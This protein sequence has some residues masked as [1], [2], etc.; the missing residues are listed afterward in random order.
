[1]E[2]KA[3]ICMN[4]LKIEHTQI[5][6]RGHTVQD[7]MSNIKHQYNIP[8][9]PRV[10]V[11]DVLAR[12]ELWHLI[13]VSKGDI[14][15]VRAVP[16]GGG[17]KNPLRT[18]LTIAVMAVAMY[19]SGG[20]LGGAFGAGTMGAALLGVGVG[21]VGSM[22][23]DAIAPLPSAAVS[24]TA[25][26]PDS[27]SFG[28]E[29]ARNQ[30]KQYGS[31]PVVLG[32]HRYAP[33]YAATPYTEILGDDQYIRML[34]CFGYGEVGVEELKI[35]ET[36]LTE[37]ADV[38]WNDYPNFDPDVD[39]LQLFPSDV[40]EEA[41]SILL[42]QASGWSL[43]TS[44]PDIDEISLDVTATRG[45]VEY[46]NAGTRIE[47]LVEYEMQYALTGTSDWSIGDN[48]TEFIARTIQNSNMVPPTGRHDRVGI[49][50]ETGEIV[51]LEGSDPVFG[52]GYPKP[53]PSDIAPLCGFT[54]HKLGLSLVVINF[55][56]LR[57]D[58]LQS[59]LPTDF[60]PT[61][62]TII[63]SPPSV[64]I[65]ISAG[66]LTAARFISG[67]T[68]QVVRETDRFRVPRG[69][70]D[71]RVRRVT[72]DSADDQVVDEITWTA[73]RS[74][75]TTTPPVTRA[76]LHLFE[77]RIRA[78]DQLNGVIDTFNALLS[79]I[80]PSWDSDTSTWITRPTNNPADIVRFIWQGAPNKRALLDAG[81]DLTKLQEWAEYCED[82][83][84]TF[85][86]PIDS[87]TSVR[88]LINRVASTGRASAGYQDGKHTVIIDKLQITPVQM[89][90][91]RN[92]KDFS[93]EKRFY[94]NPHGFRVRF[95]N[96]GA[97]FFSDERVVY[98][99]GYNE[100]NATIFE[101]LQMPGITNSDLVYK[102]AKFHL[103]QLVLRPETYKFKTDMENVVCTRGDLIYI[104]NDVILVGLTATRVKTVIDN[105]T[106]VTDIILEDETT[107][108]LGTDYGVVYR[109]DDLNVGTSQVAT[110]PGTGTSLELTA[111]ILIA[112]APS[113]GD[114]IT[115]GEFGQ[116]IIEAMVT[117]VEPDNDF[118]A[119]IFSV[120]YSAALYTAEGGTIPPFDTAISTPAGSP[121]PSF[122][123]VRSDETVQ[124]FGPNGEFIPRIII[125][126]IG[127]SQ[128]NFY[129]VDQIEVQYQALNA[130]QWISFSP[131]AHDARQLILTPV[132]ESEIYDIRFRYRFINNSVG[133]W[134]TLTH[135]V[136]GSTTNP[137]DVDG[138][139]MNPVDQVMYF[140]WDANIDRDLS[141]YEIRYT[142]NITTPAWGSATILAE[143][144]S[145][146]NTT[147]NAPLRS[148]TYM[149]KAAD[150]GGRKSTTEAVIITTGLESFGFNQVTAV[151][152]NPTYGGT[153][154]DTRVISSKLELDRPLGVMVT[155]GTYTFANAVDL[156]QIYVSRLTPSIT[157]IGSDYDDL[158]SSWPLMSDIEL[159]S[160]ATAGNW[161]IELQER[162]TDDDPAGTP[163][164]SDWATLVV[165]DYKARAFEFRIILTSI[166]P[167]ITPSI[168][169]LSITIDMPDRVDA[170]SLTTAPGGTAV[171]FSPAFKSATPEVVITIVNG[172]TGDYPV[173]TAVSRTG[174]TIQI[175][176]STGTGVARDVTW[177]AKGYG[178]VT[179]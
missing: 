141:H 108:A 7:I 179:T 120:P 87:Q 132:I 153:H 33:P 17:G 62:G 136:V 115:F 83:G 74:F 38:E 118:Q 175:K 23:I 28:I 177:H 125:D 105:G 69:Q 127:S 128:I 13:D 46:D 52:F 109:R 44:E 145:K 104:S 135:T 36:V 73:L 122:E 5:A 91:A 94:T 40:K 85:N 25:A 154:D 96:E 162:H 66:T 98:T 21:I 58:T 68:T 134:A 99:A 57:D 129:D 24:S 41:L 97:G 93:M 176:D 27:Q 26:D 12:Q 172:V 65:N 110:V 171:L 147:F 4:P 50:R 126:L 160:G 92:S 42:E 159:M 55:V 130:G 142:D 49:H 114:L 100:T 157:V 121:A 167:E 56:D 124:E 60:T 29:G 9:N 174:F 19:V 82:N 81:I 166:V 8:V 103:A 90:S 1:M 70:Y 10:F 148:G 107:M 112:E 140:R 71:I 137:A 35:G 16:T 95:P 138:F 89:F 156:S 34:F 11:N 51:W 67:K 20:A 88:E 116:E 143:R 169:A 131:L 117:R 164:W 123:S 133:P 102:H 77:M 155:E 2:N 45:M 86:Q 170:G 78:T 119:S 31:I 106:H 79:S 158:M 80:I 47:R 30:V 146:F 37:Y 53:F 14:I 15:S 151:T 72:V 32:Y 76:G 6:V 43:K 61:L 59:S 165:G 75:D 161:E 3:T 101:E 152:E 64:T 39:T 163:T 63:Q 113:V 144:V 173:L 18:I 139:S 178:R 48:P 84:Y 149:I 54:W 111:P 22:L 168:T 150:Y